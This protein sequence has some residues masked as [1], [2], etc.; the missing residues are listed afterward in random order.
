MRH[1]SIL[2]LLV[3]TFCCAVQTVA[4][5]KVQGSVVDA[6]GK[7]IEYVSV[8]AV[9]DSIGV[10]ADANGQ[11]ELEVSSEAVRL[12]FSHVS[13]EGVTVK[14]IELSSNNKVVMREKSVSLSDVSIV[15]SKKL[16]TITGKGMRGP[17]NV[18][19]SGINQSIREV[20]SVTSVGKSSTVEKIT[21]PI[22]G[23]SYDK[24][25]LSLH[26]YE[27]DGN[28]FIPVQ[29]IPI[30][31]SVDKCGKRLLA[32]EPTEKIILRKGRRYF[33]SVSLVELTGNGSVTF[34]AYFKSGYVRNLESGRQKKLPISLGLEITGREVKE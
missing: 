34:P 11:F 29:H 19:I 3:I 17:G 27:I 1:K 23:C 20:G 10:I 2:I 22:V 6:F 14:V 7:A 13:Y 28:R 15:T 4:K 12:A 33:V 5:V 18:A 16:K 8:I 30:Y 25:K 32:V 21:I 24:C 26:F 9:D 31:I